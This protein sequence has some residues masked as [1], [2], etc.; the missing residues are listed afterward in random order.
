[1]SNA[2]HKVSKGVL[3]VICTCPPKSILRFQKVQ[4]ARR[5]FTAAQVER[6]VPQ[7]PELVSDMRL[8]PVHRACIKERQR[9]HELQCALMQGTIAT[10][11]E[12]LQPPQPPGQTSA[13]GGGGKRYA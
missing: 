8:R 11:G 2:L 6:V 1:M 7:K 10:P 12:S 3:C 9:R 13:I 4:R 5:I